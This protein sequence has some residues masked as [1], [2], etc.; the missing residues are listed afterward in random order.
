M[1]RHD[2]SE[3]PT[4]G[5][6]GGPTEAG[7]GHFLRVFDRLLRVQDILDDPL[8]S[9]P[10]GMDIVDAREALDALGFDVAG[11]HRRGI[12]DAYVSRQALTSAR[13]VG[14][15]ASPLLASMVVE[16]STPLV[17]LLDLLRH[18]EF[19]FVLDEEQARFITTRADLAKP[20][21]GLLFLGYL[22]ALERELLTLAKSC[23]GSEWFQVLPQARQEQV[24]KH[25]RRQLRKRTE[26]GLEDC[27]VFTDVAILTGR[28]PGV[29]HS[30]KVKQPD[31]KMARAIPLNSKSFGRLVSKMAA[32]RNSL[33][34]GRTVLDGSRGDHRTALKTFATVR[35]LTEQAM[36]LNRATK[37]PWAELDQTTIADSAGRILAGRGASDWPFDQAGVVITAYNPGRKTRPDWENS[38]QQAALA[39]RL[40]EVGTNTLRVDCRS[41][42]GRW[43]EPSVLAIGIDQDTA[44]EMA[45][46][47]GQS[48][49]FEIDRESIRR[50]SLR[51]SNRGYESR[52]IQSCERST[53]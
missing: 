8:Y 14:A 9:V 46:A 39:Q 44:A 32:M 50:I 38:K 24:I 11:V 47:H 43:V 5:Q 15:A 28:A 41:A 51:S 12:V 17:K 42:D 45:G 49:Y 31:A 16:K 22:L 6:A 10:E 25:F 1:E 19:V 37:G 52:A 21:V 33:A 34:H 26:L 53:R 7:S 2:P 13:T 20:Q 3:V 18:K 36:Q 23:L 48:A 4:R 35:A 30:L 40:A 29:L 27:L